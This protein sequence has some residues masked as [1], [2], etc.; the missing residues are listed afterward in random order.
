MNVEAISGAAA[1]AVA[2]S[3]VFALLARSGLALARTRNAAGRFAGFIMPEAA[4]RFREQLAALHRKQWI[5]LATAGVFIVLFPF[6]YLL[7]PAARFHGL[8]AWQLVLAAASLVA[9]AAL[10]VTRLVRVVL[11]KRRLEF[12]RDA[13]IAI[14]QGLH[15]LAGNRNR[16]F[17]EVPCG[18]GVID[19]VVAGLHGIYAIYVI[20][21][22]P[23]RH[24]RIRAQGEQLLF[25]P[26][27]HRVG[28]T[29]FGEQSKLLERQLKKALKLAL[30]VRTVIA[31]PG[32][33]VE[34]QCDD[35]WLIVN[36]RSLVMVRGWKD[37]GEYLMHEDVE[38]LHDLLTERCLRAL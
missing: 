3:F 31:V 14:G 36:E 34:E 30:K 26:G 25:A 17:H 9:A 24:N 23:G 5:L 8:A 37:S 32:W 29:P 19:N 20:A 27:K 13:N 22:P 6:A 11:A 7:A 16:V 2:G 35:D 33:E 21:R 38:R 18:A 1:V 10:A 15:K 28:L 4:Q 12:V